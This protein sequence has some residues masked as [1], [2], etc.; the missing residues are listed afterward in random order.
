MIGYV[1]S[2]RSYSHAKPSAN[3]YLLPLG[4]SHQTQVTEA[5]DSIQATLN[6]N[7]S[8]SASRRSDQ[9]FLRP[10]AVARSGSLA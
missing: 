7:T 8:P 6:F 3:E 2:V 4:P 5:N 10:S 9:Y 1:T